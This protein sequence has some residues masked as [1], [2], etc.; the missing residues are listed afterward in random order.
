MPNPKATMRQKNL[1]VYCAIANSSGWC[2]NSFKN[3]ANGVTIM[4]LK[5]FRITHSTLIEHYQF[6]ETHLEGIYAA[7]CGKPFWDGLQEVEKGS[8]SSAIREIRDVEREKGIQ[9]FTD[10]EYKQLRKI[11]ERRN[12]WCHCCYYELAFDLQTGGPA[13]VQ[14]VQMLFAD[15]KAAEDWRERLFNKKIALLK[16]KT[17]K[18]TT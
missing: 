1:P 15:L 10:E 11:V 17:Q 16:E 14:D 2:Y 8:L 6:I 7:V 13:K 5:D 12:F 18:T 3:K 4:V 9:V